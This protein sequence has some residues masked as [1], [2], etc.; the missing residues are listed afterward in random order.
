MT[1]YFFVFDVESV[2]LHGEAFAVAG[3]VYLANGACQREFS[4]A[5]PIG[6]ASGDPDDRKWVNENTPVLE[7][8]HYVPIG[9]RQAF[10]KQWEEAKKDY[11]GICMAAECAWPVEAGFLAACISDNPNG[12]KFEGPYPLHEISS[13][14]AAAGMDPMGKYERISSESRIHDPLCDSRQSARLLCEA[15]GAIDLAMQFTKA[16]D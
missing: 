15:I 6:A 11:H 9:V 14:M 7:I 10:W 3:G 13:F 1:K 8:T 16:H 2:G 4:F 5:C 12:R